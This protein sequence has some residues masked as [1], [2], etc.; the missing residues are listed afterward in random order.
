MIFVGVLRCHRRS[1]VCPVPIRSEQFGAKLGARC[2]L[3][4]QAGIGRTVLRHRDGSDLRGDLLDRRG[5]NDRGQQSHL[6]YRRRMARYC[7][8][9]SPYALKAVLS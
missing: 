3:P 2:D 5:G 9:L 6:K 1:Q 4:H 7:P 8:Y